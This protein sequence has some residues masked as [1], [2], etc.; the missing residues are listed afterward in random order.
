MTCDT[1]L[2]ARLALPEKKVLFS[3]AQNNDQPSDG[4]RPVYT[5]EP[6]TRDAEVN[7]R[8]RISLIIMAGATLA[9]LI[10]LAIETY[11]ID[12]ADF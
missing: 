2:R 10:L 5:V 11:L 8:L 1:T 7:R 6:Q 4:L 12:W 3:K 9:V